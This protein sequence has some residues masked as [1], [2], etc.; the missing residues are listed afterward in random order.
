M[1][2]CHRFTSQKD[3]ESINRQKTREENLL[4]F[5]SFLF[6][7]HCSSTVLLLCFCSSLFK[8]PPPEYPVCSDWSAHPCLSQLC[9]QCLWSALSCFQLLVGFTS[10]LIV[11]VH[12]SNAW[13]DDVV[14]SGSHQITG[15]TTDE[16]F[17]ALHCDFCGRE[18]LMFEQ[19]LGFLT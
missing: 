3:N 12:Y 18:E 10:T 8:G 5:T 13:Y 19:A 2:Y 11:C 6:S 9:L 7:V 15:R 4:G 17:Q 16:A 1:F 14:M